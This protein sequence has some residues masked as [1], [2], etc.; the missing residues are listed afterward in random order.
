MEH[1]SGPDLQLQRACGPE[2]A[3]RAS[4]GQ[5]RRCRRAS[6]AAQ[7]RRLDS[8]YG[9]IRQC[10]DLLDCPVGPNQVAASPR[11][12]LPTT[13]GYYRRLLP[14]ARVERFVERDAE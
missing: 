5:A 12:V 11:R 6:G 9:P 2:C 10:N 13:F 1:L 14:A 4:Q 3:G 7:R 8:M